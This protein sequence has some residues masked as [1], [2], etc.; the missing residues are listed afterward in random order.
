MR[1]FLQ[2]HNPDRMGYS[3]QELDGVTF[4]VVTRKMY[5]LSR[6]DLVWLVGGEGKPRRFYL[7]EVFLSDQIERSKNP[8][9]RFQIMGTKGVRF[10]P[11]VELTLLPW[12][13]ELKR[14][15]GNFSFGLSEISSK[16]AALFDQSANQC[17][18]SYQKMRALL[19]SEQQ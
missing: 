18:D 6:G 12:F 17:S 3:C 16:Y 1:H 4:W 13:A 19:W 7:C 8:D 14:S 10:R 5:I 15:V 9:F 11:P 2:Y